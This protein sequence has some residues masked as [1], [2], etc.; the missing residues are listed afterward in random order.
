[1]KL[2]VVAVL[3]RAKIAGLSS[4]FAVGLLLKSFGLWAAGLVQAAIS[5]GLHSGPL[6]KA[7]NQL[8]TDIV[9][10][11]VR[12]AVALA[13]I[14]GLPQTVLETVLPQIRQYTAHAPV[15]FR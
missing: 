9:M 10:L 4:L 7:A 3:W 11:P 5:F 12:I 13:F 2:K 8:G 1:M 6:M 15:T 14:F